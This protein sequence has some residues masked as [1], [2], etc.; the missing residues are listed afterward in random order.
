ADGHGVPLIERSGE[1]D[2]PLAFDARLLRQAAPVLL[3][4]APAV[5]DHAVAFLVVR[6]RAFGHDPGKVDARNHRETA[7]DGRLPGDGETVLVVQRRVDDVD[8]DIP[9]GKGRLVEAGNVDTLTGVVLA[10]HD[11]RKHR[12]LLTWL[13]RGSPLPSLRARDC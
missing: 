3:T 5:E 8:G 13:V 11:C 10:D 1:R 9:F 2:E 7:N 12:W 6:V 4:D